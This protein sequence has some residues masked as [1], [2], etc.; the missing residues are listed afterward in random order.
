MSIK[1]PHKPPHKYERFKQGNG[2]FIW[3]CILPDCGH[4]LRRDM[5]YGR[6]SICP[7]CGDEY[8]MDRRA[9]ELNKPHCRECTKSRKE[10]E[11]VGLPEESPI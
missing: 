7:R 10:K 3:K 4:F 5:I 9:M 6:M 2:A 8:I 1:P 11:Y